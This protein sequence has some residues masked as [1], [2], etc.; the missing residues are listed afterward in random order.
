[1]PAGGRLTVVETELREETCFRA[2]DTV[3]WRQQIV[4]NLGDIN[5]S[6]FSTW[7]LHR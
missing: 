1:M 6:V 5:N 7:N 3:F 4:A 2:A